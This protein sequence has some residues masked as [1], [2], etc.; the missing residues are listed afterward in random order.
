MILARTPASCTPA[1]R[2]FPHTLVATIQFLAALP[3]SAQ[4][5][6]W[7]R[8]FGTSGAED[9]RAAAPDG[10]S[11]VYFTGST[12]ASLGGPNAGSYDA[13]LAR[14]DSAGNQTWIRQFGTSNSDSA[15]AAASDGSGGV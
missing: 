15:H 5:Q 6:L 7:I 3:A 1:I 11:G 2:W 8:Q 14:Y 4:D 10:L 9:A 13:W 12:D